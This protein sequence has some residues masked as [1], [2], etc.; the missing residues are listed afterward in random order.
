MQVEEE[1]KKQQAT[2]L[3]SELDAFKASQSERSLEPSIRLQNDR[4][5]I[6]VEVFIPY[7]KKEARNMR[8]EI[9]T[10]L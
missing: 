10:V 9:Q 1:I 5:K 2:M 7:M 4:L 6:P 8:K 3:P